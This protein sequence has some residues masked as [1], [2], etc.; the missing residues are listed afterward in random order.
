MNLRFDTA[1]HDAK[2][3]AYEAE[4][5]KAKALRTAGL[6]WEQWKS[7]VKKSK[8][9]TTA[10]LADAV[11]ELRSSIDKKFRE[12]KDLHDWLGFTLKLLDEKLG[13]LTTLNITEENRILR[14]VPKLDGLNV[15][16][17]LPAHYG[18]PEETKPET[19]VFR[20]EENLRAI[21]FVKAIIEQPGFVG[22]V[23]DATILVAMFEDGEINPVGT[24]L[25]GIG[26][27]KIPSIEDYQAALNAAQA[28]G[29]ASAT[30][31]DPE[32]AKPA[33]KPRRA[34]PSSD[35]PK[36]RRPRL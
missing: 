13:V 35:S 21:P 12:D 16:S 15:E 8:L 6:I 7:T 18:K 11:L 5:R 14:Y 29:D 1:K 36:P 32:P 33:P 25:N 2:V 34:Q 23:L 22:F 31:G 9:M 10:G 26:L 17:P 19:T 28:A 4:K 27:E 24:V 3:N 30:S 20:T